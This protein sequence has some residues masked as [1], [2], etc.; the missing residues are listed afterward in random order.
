MP[1]RPPTGEE[2]VEE[3]K[4]QADWLQQ[5]LDAVNKRIEQVQKKK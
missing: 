3:L 5:E 1:V 4:A 2:E